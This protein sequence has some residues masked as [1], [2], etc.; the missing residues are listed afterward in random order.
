MNLFVFQVT[1]I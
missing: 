1:E